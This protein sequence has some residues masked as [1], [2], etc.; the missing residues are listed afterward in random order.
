[1]LNKIKLKNFKKFQQGEFQ[2]HA[3][4]NILIGANDAGK[5]T[6]LKAI[7]IVLSQT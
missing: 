1:M 2:F 3:G 5:S 6:I 7:D 4:T